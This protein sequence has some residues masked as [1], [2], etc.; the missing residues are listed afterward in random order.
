MGP[1]LTTSFKL[2]IS[3]KPLSL[4]MVLLEVGQYEFVCWRGHSSA[5]NIRQGKED[6]IWL[7]PSVVKRK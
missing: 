5:P 3:L 4:Y 1:F 6:R 2:I 7:A